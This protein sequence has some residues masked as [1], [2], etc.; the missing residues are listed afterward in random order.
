MGGTAARAPQSRHAERQN[1]P[2]VQPAPVTGSCSFSRLGN[3]GARCLAVWWGQQPR[4]GLAEIG[5]GR[6]VEIEANDEALNGRQAKQVHTQPKTVQF[7]LWSLDRVVV[8]SGEGSMAKERE[9][10]VIDRGAP[11]KRY[12]L[13]YSQLGFCSNLKVHLARRII[14]ML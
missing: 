4:V 11:L 10:R 5:L 13:V 9:G 6:A 3:R 2:L 1:D 7:V 14:A 12:R 8:D